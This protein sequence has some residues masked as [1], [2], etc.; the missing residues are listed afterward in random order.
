MCTII[1]DTLHKNYLLWMQNF[2]KKSLQTGTSVEF[3]N[4]QYPLPNQHSNTNPRCHDLSY[5]PVLPKLCSIC[6]SRGTR[7]AGEWGW[8][9]KEGRA[10]GVCRALGGSARS[11]EE[12]LWGIR[13]I[14]K[15]SAAAY[16]FACLIICHMLHTTAISHIRAL[17]LQHTSLRLDETVGVKAPCRK[18]EDRVRAFLRTV[19]TLTHQSFPLQVY[20]N[21]LFLKT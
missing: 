5:Q 8:M 9:W 6:L 14:I 4:K 12:P 11:A 17:S 15:D 7:A 19:L 20:G 2:F 21:L 10:A 13:T 3:K 16:W 18:C 1:A